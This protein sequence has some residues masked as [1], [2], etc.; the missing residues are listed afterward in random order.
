MLFATDE[1]TEPSLA[2]PG[3]GLPKL[4]LFFARLMVT[5]KARRIARRD[6]DAF[7]ALERATIQTFAQKCDPETGSRRVLIKRLR[8]MEDSSR[9]WSVYMTLDHLRIVNA[10]VAATIQQLASGE[11]PARAASTADVKPTPGAGESVIEEFAH[12]CDGFER[13]VAAVDNLRTTQRFAHP[14]FG[15][16]DAAG[17]HFMA[18]FHMGLHRR[19]IEA[20]LASGK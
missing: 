1:I 13:T 4:E 2:A 7:F 14:W 5:W 9:Y 6:V 15:P 20:I 19:Q 8:G 16:L 3:A 18:A 17:W 12:T 10:G 11:V